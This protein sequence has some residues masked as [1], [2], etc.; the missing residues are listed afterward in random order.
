MK[1]EFSIRG[2]G[3]NRFVHRYEVDLVFL[4]K[5]DF[6]N[7]DFYFSRK[8]LETG[9]QQRIDSPSAY[10]VFHFIVSPVLPDLRTGNIEQ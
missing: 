1:K 8:A 9:H 7:E 6:L 2:C 10:I 4:Q 3:V 5:L